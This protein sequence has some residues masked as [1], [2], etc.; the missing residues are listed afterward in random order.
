MSIRKAPE[1]HVS[2]TL[3]DFGSVLGL[4]DRARNVA[5]APVISPW[6]YVPDP[7][8]LV[9]NYVW[10]YVPDPLVSVGNYV[11]EDENRNNV[12]CRL[13]VVDVATT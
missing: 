12:R 2:A 4:T 3:E 7:F 11:W 1:T 8:V 10:V 5:A 13:A 9:G 6:V